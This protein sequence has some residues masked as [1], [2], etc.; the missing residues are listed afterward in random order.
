MQKLLPIITAISLFLLAIPTSVSA[1][2]ID[3]S[4]HS[5]SI[6][7]S[8]NSDNQSVTISKDSES[9][10]DT[11][12]GI[13]TKRIQISHRP[14]ITIHRTHTVSSPTPTPTKTKNPTP[15][16]SQ[17]QNSS[18]VQQYIMNAINAYRSSKGLSAVQTDSYTCNF[19]KTRASEISKSFDHSGFQNRVNNS[20]IPYPSYHL[21]TENIA[22]MSNYKDVVNMWIQS[23]GHAAN[24]RKDTP[25]VCVEQYGNYYAYEGWRP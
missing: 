18:T 6:S 25:Y 15:T 7:V 23:P 8:T 9:N 3:I 16:Q 11:V 20:T 1:N 22:M 5:Q 21:I 17:Q 12:K 10:S 14:T 24:M 4:F 2:S 19:A 13:T